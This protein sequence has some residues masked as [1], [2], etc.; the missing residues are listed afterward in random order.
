MVSTLIISV[1][2]M[3]FVVIMF[4]RDASS[5]VLLVL[6]STPGELP[7][8][9]AGL[10]VALDHASDGAE[11][12]SRPDKSATVPPAPTSSVQ[13]LLTPASLPSRG[14]RSNG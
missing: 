11:P 12:P 8:A 14:N 10:D 1:T 5:Q 2:N 13:P 6:P 4:R 3:A 9:S 7:D